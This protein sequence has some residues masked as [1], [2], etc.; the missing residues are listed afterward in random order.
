MNWHAK[1]VQDIINQLGCDLKNGLSKEEGRQ[2]LGQ[3]GE[4]KLNEV[5]KESLLMRF[6]KQFNDFMILILIVAAGLSIFLSFMQ[7][8]HD[9]FD[10]IIILFIVVLN[11]ALGLVQESKAEK[12]LEAL[13]NMSAPNAKVI[14]G[15]KLQTIPTHELVPGDLVVLEAGDNVPADIRLT[16]TSNLKVEESA[17]TGESVPVEKEFDCVLK[18]K[19]ELGDRR[20]M[21]F[22]GSSISYGRAQ[23][24]VVETGMHTEMGKIASM[25]LSHDDPQTPLQKKL[26][27]TGKVLG[28]GALSICFVIFLLGLLRNIEP[29]EMFM[30]SVSLAVAA[31]PEGLPAIVTIMLAIGVQRMAKRNAVIRKLPAVETLGSASVICSDKTGTLTQNK[32]KVVEV[33]NG[34]ESLPRLDETKKYILQL[35]TMC[36]DSVL[37]EGSLHKTAQGDPTET[38]IVMAALGLGVDKNNLDRTF[39]RVAEVPFESSRKLMSTIH[40]DEQKNT[41]LIVTKGAP[42]VLIEKCTHYYDAH[43]KKQLTSALKAK[44]HAENNKLADK[45]L[46]VLGVAYKEVA[47][48]PHKLTP[49]GVEVELTF[50]GLMGMIDPPREEVREAVEICKNAGIK[51]VMITGDHVKTATAIASKIGIMDA[52]DKALTG[53]QLT[54]ISDEELS[55]TIYRYS[56]FA[57]VSPEHKVRI[58][59]AFQSTGAIVAMTGDG[60]NDAPAL[61]AADIGC[62]MGVSGTDVAKGAA[63]MVL[64]DDNFATI[65]DAVREGRGIYANIRKSVHFLLSSNIGEIL[66]ILTAVL[67]GFKSPLLA[68]HLLW[69]NLVTDSLPAIA[70]G[71][72]PADEKIMDRKPFKNEKNLFTK[73]LWVR[74]GLEGCMIG[75]L[76]L[77]AFSIGNVLFGS[78]T[79][80]RTMAF[81]TLSISQLVHAFNMRTEESVFSIDLLSNMYLIGA[82]VVGFAMQAAVIM[83]PA[84]ALIFKVI[85]LTAIQW[86]VVL[87]LSF[88]PIA[89][90]EAEKAL[91]AH[92]K[93]AQPSHGAAVQEY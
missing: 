78:L 33:S 3:Y 50:V 7:G 71:L 47:T 76:A 17:L 27:E 40:R 72:D 37:E 6:I 75:L 59:K 85:P 53:A 69:V 66:T 93:K 32:M 91:W 31:I 62:A 16:T 77:T 43:G 41:F 4:N 61:K 8:E 49:E 67:M 63:D 89:V 46:R 54:N 11:A 57:R 1:E 15:G 81:A 36:N 29:F 23:G 30:T 73:S 14:R 5:K 18:E 56:V 68:I 70:L 20:N 60:V 74:I 80:G 64:T 21:V 19:L 83:I 82:F 65:V 34:F 45:A 12:A 44:I 51:A 26:S 10:A 86:L 84:V 25:I 39:M 55:K 9:Y 2:R 38:A 48:K 79:I 87:G 24:I 35:A 42:D 90:V 22:T 88:V 52:Y 13:K 28:I 92:T 58:V